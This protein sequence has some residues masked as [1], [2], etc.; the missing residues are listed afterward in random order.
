M[1]E[2][3]AAAIAGTSA[4]ASANLDERISK[5]ERFFYQK[6]Y[7]IYRLYYKPYGAGIPSTKDFYFDGPLYDAAQRAKE[8]CKKM[9]IAFIIVRPAIVDL[10]YQEERRA[11][12]E[13]FED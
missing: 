9:E 6:S 5:L 7:R 8:H 13:S 2:T 4:Q 11:Q 10:D 12:N 3:K 1:A